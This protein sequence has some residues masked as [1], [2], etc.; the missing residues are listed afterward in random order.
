MRP[1]DPMRFTDVR[2]TWQSSYTMSSSMDERLYSV[3]VES[4]QNGPCTPTGNQWV[5]H[6]SCTGREAY[7]I[8][9]CC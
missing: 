5:R 9:R 1:N 4:K 7:C 3:S 8:R 2:C 6:T